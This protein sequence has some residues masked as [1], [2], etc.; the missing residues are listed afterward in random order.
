M[1]DQAALDTL[2]AAVAEIGGTRRGE[3]S[4]LTNK[5]VLARGYYP[6]ARFDYDDW[7]E[8]DEV[9]AAWKTLT[10]E[11][12]RRELLSLG[13]IGGHPGG[14]WAEIVCAHALPGGATTAGRPTSP[15][16]GCKRRC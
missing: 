14:G 3:I 1:T 6:P 7:V 15:S 13:G 11:L 16:W 10:D 12:P 2:L 8:R 4:W 9:E 5:L